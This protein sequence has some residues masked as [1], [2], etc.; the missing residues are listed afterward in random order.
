M[1]RRS[2]AQLRKS[3]AVKLVVAR[4]YARPDW[5]SLWP[6]DFCC[7]AYEEGRLAGL[8]EAKKG[9]KP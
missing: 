4:I 2:L 9:R 5:L 7:L 3:K 6:S 1:K 8:A